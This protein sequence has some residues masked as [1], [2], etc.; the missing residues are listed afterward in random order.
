MLLQILFYT[1]H[2]TTLLF[3]VFLSAFFLGVNQ[4]RKNIG[5]LL[6]SALSSGLLYLISIFLMVLLPL[7]NPGNTYR[8]FPAVQIS[9]SDHRPALREI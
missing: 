2:L 8:V 6:L 3:G 5:I 1:H 4:D 9:V 7:Q